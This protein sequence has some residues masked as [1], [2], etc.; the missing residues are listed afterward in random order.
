[1]K[2]YN[3]GK[4]ITMEQAHDLKDKSKLVVSDNPITFKTPGYPKSITA[5]KE[6]KK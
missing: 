6:K 3:D 1:M 4:E 2:Y 5:K